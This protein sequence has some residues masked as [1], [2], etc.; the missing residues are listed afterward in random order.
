VAGQELVSRDDVLAAQRRIRDEQ[1]A[2]RLSAEEAARRS[3]A[4]VH[5]VTP[6]DLYE[7]SGGLAGS[8]EISAAAKTDRTKSILVFVCIVLAALIVMALVVWALLR[9]GED[10]SGELMNAMATAAF[11]LGLG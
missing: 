10:R 5:A 2:G 3:E 11:A 4:V 9:E 7:A 6:H 8:A 1:A